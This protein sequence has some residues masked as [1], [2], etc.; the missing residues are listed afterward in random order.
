MDDLDPETTICPTSEVAK[1]TQEKEFMRKAFEKTPTT[2]VVKPYNKLVRGKK[3]CLAGSCLSSNEAAKVR[4][5]CA[6][7]K[8]SYVDRYTKDL[9]HLVVGV[10]EENKSQRYVHNC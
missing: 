4:V 1:T 5:L 10:D 8:W 6:Q 2:Q 3:F 7:Y 9:T